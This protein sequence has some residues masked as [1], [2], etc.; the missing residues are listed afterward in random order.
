MKHIRK[1]L[2]LLLTVA[3]LLSAAPLALASDDALTRGEAV[4]LVWEAAAR[5]QPETG[6]MFIDVPADSAYRTAAVWG[7]ETGVISG[8]GDGY[9]G[10]DVPLTR[11]QFLT[12]L[13]RYAIIRG[14]DVS[15]GEDTNLLSYADAS[16]VDEYAVA[17]FQW[18]CGAGILAESTALQPKSSVAKAEAEAWL[19]ELLAKSGEEHI[20]IQQ[21]VLPELPA[22]VL[23]EEFREVLRTI[24]QMPD[25]PTVTTIQNGMKWK[26]RAVRGK[27]MSFLCLHPNASGVSDSE[28]GTTHGSDSDVGTTYGGNADSECFLIS[29]PVTDPKGSHDVKVL[30]T[31]DVEEEAVGRLGEVVAEGDALVV[32]PYDDVHRIV[33]ALVVALRDGALPVAA[34]FVVQRQLVVVVANLRVLAVQRNPCGV[35][36]RAFFTFQLQVAA[37]VLVDAAWYA[38]SRLKEAVVD[39]DPHLAPFYDNLVV[40]GHTVGHAI[41]SNRVLAVGRTDCAL[42]RRAKC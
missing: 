12:M 31:G 2:A 27:E 25:P 19:R 9:F 7:A 33:L 16:D 10:A 6:A 22:D 34:L 28:A 21:V 35:G 41:Y 24:G 40:I 5:P 38:E 23:Q 13:Y 18:A 30:L 15:M 26:S 1:T 3:L 39:V 14:V 42:L 4:E 17:A 36:R 37:P 29:F 11:E 8:V 20:R 32:G